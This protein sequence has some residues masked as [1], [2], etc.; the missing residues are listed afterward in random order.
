MTS[1]NILRDN[2]TPPQVR[3]SILQASA[4]DNMPAEWVLLRE[5]NSRRIWR[6]DLPTGGPDG[7]SWLV[8][9]IRGH[10]WSDGASFFRQRSSEAEIEF[11]NA[12]RAREA[13]LPAAPLRLLAV[14]RGWGLSSRAILAGE[15]LDGARDLA[16]AFR[17]AWS[18][19]RERR[20]LLDELAALAARLH[21]TGWAHGDFS[22]SNILT[23]AAGRL[24]LADWLK[25]S[26][27]DNDS[28]AS[29]EK[30]FR[31]DLARVL[32]DLLFE[33]GAS[34]RE[35]ER[36]LRVYQ[37]ETP[38][39]RL[40]EAKDLAASLLA[41]ASRRRKSIAKRA[42]ENALDRSRAFEEFALDGWKVRAFKK[43]DRAF[44]QQALA[45]FPGLDEPAPLEALRRWR[46]A[47]ALEKSGLGGH[48]VAGL[49]TRRALGMG[50]LRARLIQ[51]PP[52]DA[53]PLSDA[54]QRI[55]T[56][57]QALRAGQRLLRLLRECGLAPRKLE[58]TDWLFAP[59]SEKEPP[60][61]LARD[62]GVFDW[63]KDGEAAPAEDFARLWRR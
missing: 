56:R 58:P 21:R 63:A 9:A 54:L 37:A 61:V 50:P 36:F 11:D 25:A 39:S 4:S 51:R 16:S 52:E 31:A 60:Q 38:L 46:I 18:A 10:A 34:R 23:D 2:A 33:S 45:P 29:R 57:R 17:A 5:S 32:G 55:E 20:R 13:G 59:A 35:L 19:P 48:L 6:A 14:R 22:G 53:L 49:A 27:V 24:W 26:R 12:L 28:D 15:F 40:A 47:C 30:A 1:W 44:I 41:S 43:T 3:D 7:R 62:A 8:K 42:F